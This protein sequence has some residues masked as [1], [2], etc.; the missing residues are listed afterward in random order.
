MIL[1]CMVV[2]LRC[3]CQI[4]FDY[5][6]VSMRYA[7]CGMLAMFMEKIPVD[8]GGAGRPIKC[9]HC[10]F[11]DVAPYENFPRG[12][13]FHGRSHESLLSLSMS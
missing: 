9:W 13:D 11:D 10:V 5:D 1:I 2:S 8:N 3:C 4:T 12:I 6:M 7:V